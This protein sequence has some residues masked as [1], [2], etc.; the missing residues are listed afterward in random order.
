MRSAKLLRF[1]NRWPKPIGL[2]LTNASLPK[3]GLE[4]RV[5]SGFSTVIAVDLDP[6]N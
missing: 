1:T 2:V 6:T 3:S 4:C 5:S